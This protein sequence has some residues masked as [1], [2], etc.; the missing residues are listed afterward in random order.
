MKL[1]AIAAFGSMAL[2]MLSI[3]LSGIAAQTRTRDQP[4]KLVLDGLEIEFDEAGNWIQMYSTYRQ[5]VSFPDRTG[6]R[7]AYIIAEEK[8][9]AQIIRFM[10]EKVTSER[11]IEE[12][13]KE[14]Q[15]ALRRQSN[16]T[17]SISRDTQR[18]MVESIKE[19]TRSYSAGTLRGVTILE[20]GYDEKAEEVWVSIGLS[21][22]TAAL[23]QQLQGDLRNPAGSVKRG[24]LNSRDTTRSPTSS[25]M[26]GSEVRTR[27]PPQ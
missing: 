16:G 18:E 6:L 8:G 7:K 4:A 9:K 23:G 27:R 26:Q 14:S 5:P 21:R 13:S 25:G 17:Q 3:P 10:E 19:F 20:Q 11:L 15:T 2:C 1:R 22:R 12:V 24:G